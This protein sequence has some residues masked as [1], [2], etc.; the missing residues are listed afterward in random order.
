M[1]KLTVTFANPFLIFIWS[2]AMLSLGCAIGIHWSTTPD[3]A[4]CVA[5]IGALLMVIHDMVMSVLWFMAAA[6]LLKAQQGGPR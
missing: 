5:A 6:M 1:G 3:M 2:L 4:F